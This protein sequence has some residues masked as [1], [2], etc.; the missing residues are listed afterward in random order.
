[1]INNETTTNNI[2]WK[3]IL[4]IIGYILCSF[5]SISFAVKID[6]Y[7]QGGNSTLFSPLV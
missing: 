3:E 1:M 2:K 5:T 7:V 6:D 4:F